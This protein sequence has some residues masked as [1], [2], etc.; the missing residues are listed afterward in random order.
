MDPE[1]LTDDKSMPKRKLYSNIPKVYQKESYT[2]KFQCELKEMK[3]KH[4]K[5][6]HNSELVKLETMTKL[7]IVVEMKEYSRRF[8]HKG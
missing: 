1:H 3:E 6:Q 7:R 4:R 5:K 2:L 8:K